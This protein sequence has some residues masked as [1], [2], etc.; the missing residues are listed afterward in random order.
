IDL[1]ASTHNPPADLASL[2]FDNTY[3]VWWSLPGKPP[4][5]TTYLIGK[6]P[7]KVRFS[8]N[9]LLATGTSLFGPTSDQIFPLYKN[10]VQVGAV[11]FPVAGGGVAGFD[12]GMG[13]PF[14]DF[15]KDDEL[16]VSTPAVQD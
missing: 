12:S 3:D 10:G 16:T 5:A 4:A 2:E 6:F 1:T 11:N 8:G 14:V 9:F 15:D 7:H 13:G